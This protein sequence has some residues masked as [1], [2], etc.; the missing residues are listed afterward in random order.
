MTAS[1]RPSTRRSGPRRFADRDRYL[2][3]AT[4][5]NLQ[6]AEKRPG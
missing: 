2:P 4:N 3:F 6:A 5:H 1:S